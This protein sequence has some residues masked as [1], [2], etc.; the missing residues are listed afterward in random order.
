M[1]L[2][3]LAS[4][5][6]TDVKGVFARAWNAAGRQGRATDDYE[7]W[8]QDAEKIPPY[9]RDFAAQKERMFLRELP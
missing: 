3:K 1:H 7:A 6:H 4:L 5:L 9:V 8:I 2:T